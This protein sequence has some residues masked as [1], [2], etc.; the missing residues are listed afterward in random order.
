[1]F[2][3][4]AF[5]WNGQDK[6]Q[7]EAAEILSMRL[8]HISEEWNEVANGVGRRVFCIGVGPM[9]EPYV[10]EGGAGV[11]LGTLFQREQNFELAPHKARLGVGEARAI[12]DSQGRALVTSFWGRYVAFL[13]DDACRKSWVLK[14]PV[15]N[16]PCF[17]TSFRGVTIFFS[18]LTDCEQLNLLRFSVNWKYIAT[19][20]ALGPVHTVGTA[21]NEVSEIH[22]GECLELSRNEVS[23]SFYWRPSHIVPSEAVEGPINAAVKLRATV[24]HCI[25]AWASCHPNII[26]RLSGGLDSSIVLACIAGARSRPNIT[27]LTYY[28]S[29]SYS[30]ERIYARHAARRAKCEHIERPRD[31]QIHLEE[32]LHARRSAKPAKSL[33]YL[34]ARQ[35]E[36][37]LATEKRASAIFDGEGGDSL[38]GAGAKTQAMSD[39]VR[40]HGVRLDMF[41]LASDLALMMNSTIWKV[42]AGG[43]RDGLVRTP[44]AQPMG[45]ADYRKLVSQSAMDQVSN[46]S[47]YG[48]PWFASDEKLPR[49]ALA[50]ALH[51]T[52]PNAFYDP[53]GPHDDQ[54]VDRLSP[55]FS[56]PIVELCLSIPS[57]I[58]AFG[59]RDRAV[60]RNAFSSDLPIEILNR[61]WKDRGVGNPE[62]V[63]MWNLRFA[64]E[65]LLDGVLLKQGLLDKSRLEDVLSGR[66]TKSSGFVTEVFD[67]LVTESWLR[68]W[69]VTELSH[70]P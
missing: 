23:R 26:L 47:R 32:I 2:R 5:V 53:L 44:V 1:M 30:D 12:L 34:E 4:M 62:A 13:F 54:I 19:R 65:M 70:L 56:Q 7:N 22:G 42:L 16:L 69:K 21:L 57:Y 3:Y 10:M 15:G 58:Q 36:R 64:R 28:V 43:V 49:S 20:V 11:V 18:S 61:Q 45:V 35:Y 68:S 31:P 38:F 52:L 8:R 29:G 9:G 67:H 51:V 17:C 14:D 60:A 40:R 33:A 39:Y 63:F 6:L 46:T 48:H 27:G 41:R 59:G 24:K 66:P 50:P 37:S 25:D 55:L